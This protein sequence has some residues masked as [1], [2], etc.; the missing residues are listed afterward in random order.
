MGDEQGESSEFSATFTDKLVSMQVAS[1]LTLK[2]YLFHPNDTAYF[3]VNS[4]GT[5]S[6]VNLAEN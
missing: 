4:F 5:N 1:Q 6:I 2:E 3:A